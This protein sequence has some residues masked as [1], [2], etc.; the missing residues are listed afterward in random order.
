[1]VEEMKQAEESGDFIYI[2]PAEEAEGE[3]FQDAKSTDAADD[4]STNNISQN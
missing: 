2:A 4:V 1:M 3:D